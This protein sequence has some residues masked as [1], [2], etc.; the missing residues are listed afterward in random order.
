MQNSNNNFTD[1][2]RSLSCKF[3]LSHVQW[4]VFFLQPPSPLPPQ[5]KW[6]HREQ[7]PHG[8]NSIQVWSSTQRSTDFSIMSKRDHNNCLGPSNTLR[9]FRTRRP[10]HFF[11]SQRHSIYVNCLLLNNAYDRLGMVYYWCF[12][13]WEMSC[14]LKCKRRRLIQTSSNVLCAGSRF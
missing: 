6:G 14:R 1:Q 10:R 8:T 11:A 2:N 3:F 9:P 5:G 7:K 13:L 12:Y 4:S